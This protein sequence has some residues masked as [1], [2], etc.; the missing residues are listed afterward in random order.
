M[1]VVNALLQTGI[2]PS[3]LKTAI[4]LPIIINETESVKKTLNQYQ[5]VVY[6]NM[7]LLSMNSSIFLKIF[8]NNIPQALNILLGEYKILYSNQQSKSTTTE[9]KKKSSR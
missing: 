2:V 3:T 7:T 8:R 1:N 6:I 4:M 9:K 5:L